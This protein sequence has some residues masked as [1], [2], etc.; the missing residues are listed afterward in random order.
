VVNLRERD[1]KTFM[2][3]REGRYFGN[4]VASTTPRM[5]PFSILMAF[6]LDLRPATPSKNS[7][8][9]QTRI[10]NGNWTLALHGAGYKV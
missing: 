7:H 9:L 10:W 3:R 1:Y 8:D 4:H 5:L 2:A 6:C